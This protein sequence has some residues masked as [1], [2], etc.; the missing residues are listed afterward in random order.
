MHRSTILFTAIKKASSSYFALLF[1]LSYFIF[2]QTCYIL[3]YALFTLPY[4]L[5]LALLL[6]LLFLLLL[7]LL[8]FLLFR[9]VI[10][11]LKLS[12]PFL[13]H[14]LP[15]ILPPSLFSHGSYLSRLIIISIISF[16]SCVVCDVQWSPS[17]PA[18]FSTI[19][20]GGC[21]ALWN[22]RY[23]VPSSCL[24]QAASYLSRFFLSLFVLD[25]GVCVCVCV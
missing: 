22:L 12:S 25:C 6:F 9:S 14:F 21:L 7:L 16:H 20:S 5:L 8:L 1:L 13:F 3:L 18:V 11:L 24:V 15:V 10:M 17:H 23:E 19:T 4:Y 2:L